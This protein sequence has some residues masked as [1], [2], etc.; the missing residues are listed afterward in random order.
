MAGISGLDDFMK[1]LNGFVDN[2]AKLDEVSVNV[3]LLDT[4]ST[5]EQKLRAELRRKGA[6]GFSDAEIRGMAEDLLNEAR[7]RP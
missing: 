7:R 1:D 2:V 4:R 5:V 3:D 6:T